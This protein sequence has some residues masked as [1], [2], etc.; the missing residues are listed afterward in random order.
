MSEPAGS[1]DDH[2]PH[3]IAGH[4]YEF[5]VIAEPDGH[6]RIRCSSHSTEPHREA[7]YVVARLRDIADRMEA[8]Q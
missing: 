8:S 1:R 5:I 7:A 6:Y 2:P 4:E 3:I